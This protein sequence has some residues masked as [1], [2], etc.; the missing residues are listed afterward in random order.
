MISKKK[1]KNPSNNVGFVV[2]SPIR[3]LKQLRTQSNDFSVIS[4]NFRAAA[5]V[6]SIYLSA[7]RVCSVDD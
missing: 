5:A 3:R 6:R 2:G 7:G 1:K 4:A